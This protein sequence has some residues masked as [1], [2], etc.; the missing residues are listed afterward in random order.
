[1]KRLLWLIPIIACSLLCAGQ[2][3]MMRVVPLA[4]G[5]TQVAASVHTQTTSSAINTTGATVLVGIVLCNGSSYS[6]PSD[7]N[8]NS[9]TQVEFDDNTA[10]GAIYLAYS[11]TVGSGHTFTNTASTSVCVLFVT[12]WTGTAL[13]SAALDKADGTGG[14]SCPSPSPGTDTPS[15]TSEL[16]IT[17]FVP[18]S[19]TAGV[20]SI[21]G[22][23]TINDTASISGGT[24][25]MAT[26]TQIYNSGSALTPTWTCSGTAQAIPDDVF[27]AHP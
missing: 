20:P 1:M 8:S 5:I 7:S 26:A 19:S 12:A 21:A 10:H 18:V 25:D 2:G 3:M 16:V 6:A 13:G 17:G 15:K 11:P 24:I 9:W 27:I 23:F 22:G 14:A 4:N